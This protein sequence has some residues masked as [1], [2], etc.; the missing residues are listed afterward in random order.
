MHFIEEIL[1]RVLKHPACADGV[2]RYRVA[3]ISASP[4]KR[5]TAFHL[6]VDFTKAANLETKISFCDFTVDTKYVCSDGVAAELQMQFIPV[7]KKEDIYKLQAIEISEFINE[8][9]A[10]WTHA[11]SQIL[12]SKCRYW[13]D[14]S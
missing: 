9:D 5:A 10:E 8:T 11:A 3:H 2:R 7:S 4:A 6:F 1:K 12:K 14:R 13:P